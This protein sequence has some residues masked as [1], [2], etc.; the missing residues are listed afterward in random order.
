MTHIILRKASVDTWE[1]IGPRLTAMPEREA[2][3]ELYALQAKYPHQTF[4]AAEIKFI[5]TS[6]R[7]VEV[8]DAPQAETPRLREISK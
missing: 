2:H 1:P 5:S 6:K 3:K 4:A 7:T 8:L